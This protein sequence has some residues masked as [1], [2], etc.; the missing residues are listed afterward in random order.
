MQTTK[1]KNLK[2]QTNSPS[3]HQ[4]RSSLFIIVFVTG[5]FLS[6]GCSVG[7]LVVQAPTPTLPPR[8]TI[9]PTF[10]PTPYRTPTFTPTTT[11]TETPSPTPTDTPTPTPTEPP[12]EESDSAA[13]PAAEARSEPAEPTATPTP[14]E[15]TATPTPAFP[16]N[17]VYYQHDTGSPGETRMTGWI[18]ADFGPGKFK[19]LANFQ[20]NVVAPDGNTY[21]SEMS[22]PGAT[23]S[24]VPGTGDNHL[25]NTK[26]EITPYTPGTYRL[27]LVE[28]GLQVSPEVELTLSADP[29]QYVHIDFFK[30]EG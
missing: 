30:S 7:S 13:Q 9:K 5:L 1:E 12:P 10:T 2:S 8:K 11:P 15:P 25:M 21:L 24:T 18:R 3:S 4:N 19:S 28:G 26:L 29:L 14:E 27:F 23:D 16:F 6:L 20:I 22:G 17:V